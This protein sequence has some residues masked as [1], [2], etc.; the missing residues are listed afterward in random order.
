MKRKEKLLFEKRFKK[1]E[2]I[3]LHKFPE[4]YNSYE[5]GYSE[6]AMTMQL[7]EIAKF[8]NRE[9]LNFIKEFV[10]KEITHMNRRKE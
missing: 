2:K 5:G 1:W 10:L 9:K 6:L 3:F 4:Y 7:A 8:K